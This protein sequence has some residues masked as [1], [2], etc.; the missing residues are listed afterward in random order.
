MRATNR[1]TLR[2]EQ[3]VLAS[4]TYSA[5]CQD[6]GAE[7]ECHGVQALVEGRLRWDVEATCAF[8]GF[9]AAICGG[10]LPSELREQVLAE[11][12]PATL[13]ILSAPTKRVVILRVLRSELCLDLVDAKTV[14]G[15]VLSDDYTGTLPEV[16]LL[17]RKLRAAGIAAVASRL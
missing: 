12:R 7:S 13:Q 15:R 9:A 6:C 16:E 3:A 14:L 8:C 4:V 2:S 5:L 1:S 10:D 11:H 17:A